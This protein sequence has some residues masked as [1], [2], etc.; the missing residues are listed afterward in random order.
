VLVTTAASYSIADLAAAGGVSRRTV[1]F[2][3]QRG[4]LPPPGSLGRGARYTTAHLAR[5]LEIKAWQEQGVPLEEIRGRLQDAQPDR[6]AAGAE[7]LAARDDRPAHRL[8][9]ERAEP[10]TPTAD[11]LS[12]LPGSGWFRQPLARGFEL[13]VAAAVRPLTAQQLAALAAALRDI[14]NN[15][16]EEA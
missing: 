14:V 1:R 4:L 3:V 2:Y 6:P 5:L 10:A 13:H 7:H 16:G 15:G 11:A 12:G 9:L 8:S